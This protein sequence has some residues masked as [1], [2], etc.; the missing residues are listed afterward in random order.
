MLVLSGTF[1]LSDLFKVFFGEKA[2]SVGQDTI[3]EREYVSVEN[4]T[5]LR[6]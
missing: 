3:Q 2:D 4:R 5:Q 6:H 1:I